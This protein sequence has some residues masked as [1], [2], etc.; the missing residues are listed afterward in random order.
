LQDEFEG[1]NVRIQL[2]APGAAATDIW[3]TAG[4]SLSNL[5]PAVVMGAED[6]VDASLAGLDQGEKV[7][8]PSLENTSLLGALDDARAAVLTASRT[9]RPASRY[10]L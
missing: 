9:G 4:M 2:V 1:T 7:S 3:E 6:V 5:D 8:V 10:G